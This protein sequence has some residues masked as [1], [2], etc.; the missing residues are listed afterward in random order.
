MDDTA[1]QPLW[2][3]QSRTVDIVARKDEN[4]SEKMSQI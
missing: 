3:K 2:L 1:M 4:Q